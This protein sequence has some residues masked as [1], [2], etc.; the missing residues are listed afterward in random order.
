VDA[1][2]IVAPISTADPLPVPSQP[3]VTYFAPAGRDDPDEFRRKSAAVRD[4]PLLRQVLDAMP[5][6]VLILNANRQI[7]AASET[8]L[9]ALS[10]T[11]GQVAEKRPGEALGCIRVKE[12]PD[13]CGTS[14]H[15]ITCG[16]ANAILESQC[17][18]K[19]V[20]RECRVLV[21]TPSGIAAMDLRVTA[22]LF[23]M[24]EDRFIVAAVEDISQSK[25]LAVLQSAFFHDALNTA[26]CIQGYAQYLVESVSSEQ[27]VCGRLVHLSGQLIETIRAQRDLMYAESG[28]FRMHPVPVRIAQ[29][30]EELVSQYARHVV[31][32][33]R[34]I[35]LKN[36][37]EATV[38][39]D[40]QLLQRVLG[41]MLKNALE[42][43]PPG[44]KV[45]VGC[46]DKGGEAT[47]SVHNP[48]IMPEEV[49]LQVFQRSFST[50]GQPGRGIGTYSMRLFGERYLGGKVD[51]VSRA[52]QGTTFSLTIPKNPP[53]QLNG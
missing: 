16:A 34:T 32:Q 26:G 39:T 46:D 41:N 49:Q 28:D 2:S 14:R 52:P 20:A 4:A 47:F 6:M 38:I 48:G 7:V 8:A 15:C 23:S 5:T 3:G 31:A 53:S 27:E 37:C 33:G 13:G 29:A 51:F 35:E 24:G 43:I 1:L 12:G 9:N 22:S 19:K 18:E 36:A 50:K 10:V 17:K 42:A 30:L 25:R 21:D 40:P 11:I 45:T 44:G